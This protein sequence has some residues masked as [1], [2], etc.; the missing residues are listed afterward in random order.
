MGIEHLLGG[1]LGLLYID[2]IMVPQAWDWSLST[3]SAPSTNWSWVGRL[4]TGVLLSY[5]A[6]FNYSIHDKPFTLHF[7]PGTFL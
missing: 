6:S 4:V 7:N 5:L 3:C 1:L 2:V